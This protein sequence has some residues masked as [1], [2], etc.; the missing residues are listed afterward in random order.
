V[1]ARLKRQ[2]LALG[3]GRNVDFLAELALLLLGAFSGFLGALMGIGGGVIVVP[4]LILFFMLDAHQAVGTSLVMIIFTA[5]SST[6]AYHRQKR[7]DWKIGVLA[8]VTTIPG[9]SLG[10]YT[11]KFFA[12]E[13]LGIIFGVFL[14]LVAAMMIRR[15]FLTN[16]SSNN[17]ATYNKH[18]SELLRRTWTRR[19]VDASG[20]IFEYDANIHSGLLLSFLGGFASGFLGIGGGLIVVPIFAIVIGLPMHLAVATSMVTMIFT[21]ISGVSTHI[22]LGN[23][24]IEYAVPLIIGITFGTQ[25]GATAARR[26]RSKTLERI[27][28]IAVL[29]IGIWLIISRL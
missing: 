5:L 4:I 24:R 19:I 7:I 27:F 16:V 13:S 6:W 14:L 25:A 15:S 28:A 10:A 8:A 23:V 12:S 9:A 21:S 2:I 20:K 22:M 18:T 11:T 29:A 3:S 26:L 17:P 1:F